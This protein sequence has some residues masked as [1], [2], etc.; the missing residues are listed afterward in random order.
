MAELE[1]LGQRP[2]RHPVVVLFPEVRDELLVGLGSPLAG[3]FE[4]PRVRAGNQLPA[5][6]V[7]PRLGERLREAGGILV[8]EGGGAPEHVPHLHPHRDFEAFD[9]VHDKH[10]QPPVEVDDRLGMPQ[11]RSRPV[12][13][14]HTGVRAAVVV[15]VLFGLAEGG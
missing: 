11:P 14:E 8:R 7:G 3:A 15:D 13:A 1:Q 9:A 2:D 6:G 12:A 4:P 5:V 10:A